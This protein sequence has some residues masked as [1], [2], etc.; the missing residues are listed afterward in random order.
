M[1]C[2]LTFSPH[3]KKDGPPFLINYTFPAATPK[4]K[5]Q[6]ILNNKVTILFKVTT[7]KHERAAGL[8]YCSKLD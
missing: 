3:T 4:L 7:E 8:L 2:L 1:K 5:L 6:N